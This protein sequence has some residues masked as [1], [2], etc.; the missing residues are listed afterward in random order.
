MVSLVQK[1]DRSATTQTWGK[2][3]YIE[4]PFVGERKK[5]HALV[6]DLK[7]KNK[8]AGEEKTIVGLKKDRGF[9]TSYST[10][11][12]GGPKGCEEFGE[13]TGLVGEKYNSDRRGGITQGDSMS[14]SANE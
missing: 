2:M 11:V 9:T 13:A 4:N 12:R 5:K 6:G 3:N 14:L 1:K 8:K 10:K 7:K